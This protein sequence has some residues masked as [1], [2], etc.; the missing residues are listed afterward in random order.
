MRGRVEAL[1]AHAFAD[2]GRWQQELRALSNLLED[3]ETRARH[4]VREELGL[5]DGR[6]NAP[7]E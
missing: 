3:L 5:D 6:G 7:Q 1:V 4:R 2:L